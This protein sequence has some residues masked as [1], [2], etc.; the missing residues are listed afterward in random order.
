MLRIVA[1]YTLWPLLVVGE[2]VL[3]YVFLKEHPAQTPLAI[4]ATALT[5]F[6]IFASLE[7]WLPLRADWRLKGDRELGSDMVHTISATQ[8]G[9]HIGEWVIPLYGVVAAGQLGLAPLVQL[10]PTSWPYYAQILLFVFCADGLEYGLHRLT[11]TVSWLWPLHIVH[12]TPERLHIFKAGRHHFA[13]FRAP[14]GSALTV[15]VHW[16][17]GNCGPVV[18]ARHYYPRTDRPRK[19]SASL[20]ILAAQDHS[21]AGCPPPPSLIRS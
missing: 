5:G 11:H 17:T 4:G 15:S 14:P 7:A 8:L 12:H 16:R 19:L 13:Y 9:V 1:S 18:S 21:D 10:W 6:P 20:P 3:L 2:I